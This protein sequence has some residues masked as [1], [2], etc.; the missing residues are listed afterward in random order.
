MLLL[1]LL[2]SL[3]VLS[4]FAVRGRWCLEGWL[5]SLGLVVGFV[6]LVC[7]GVGSGGFVGSGCSSR[8]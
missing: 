8:V 6:G 5:C 4:T 2:T 7:V 3:T 1:L